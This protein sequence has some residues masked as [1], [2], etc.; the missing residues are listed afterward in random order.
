LLFA[1]H[2]V[3]GVS[4]KQLRDAAGTRN[5]SVVQYHFGGRRGL[6]TEILRLHL[7]AI[8][9]RRARLVAA[10]VAEDRTTDLRSLIHALAAPMADDLA[11]PVGRAHLRLV[12]QLNHPSR[13]YHL[14]FQRTEPVT[15]ADTHAG[16][17]VVSWLT[18]ALAHLPRPVR[19]ERLAAL[20]EQL[21]GLFA[22][23]AQLLDDDPSLCTAA[24]TALF[25]EN[26]LDMVVAGLAIEP[27]ES[28]IAVSEPT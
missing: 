16:T 26:F 22:A 14:P 6:V 20:R 8:E 27:S 18:I 17:A 12:A 25:L 28:A 21:I 23:R 5:E 2:S 24:N 15:E 9:T 10:I 3:A 11:D 7:D 4:T 13:A 19:T 1:R